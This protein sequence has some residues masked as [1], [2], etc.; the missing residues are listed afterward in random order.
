LPLDHDILGHGVYTPREAARLIG[1]TPQHVFRWTRGSGPTNPL[2]NA[3]YQFIEDS[4]E[5][6]F[7]DLIE[8]RVVAAMRRQGI[9]L[10]SIR[11]AIDFAQNALGVDRPL[12]SRD[13]KTDGSE[14]LM[15]AVEDDGEFVSLSKKAPGQKVFKKIIE[16][17]LN[18]LEYE[19]DLVARWRPRGFESI[20]LDPARSFG[21][22]LL[23]EFGVSTAVVYREFQQFDDAKYLS[24]IYEIPLQVV[25]I[26]IKYEQH[27]DK[28]LKGLDGQGSVRS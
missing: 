13:F 5:I 19:N 14:I 11:Y 20:V 22:P 23:D 2:W 8:V 16:Q 26:A 6:S 1:E 24:R 17:S 12:S 3:H 21:D 15:D 10:Q 27:L 25:R 18:D 4:T 28:K 9:S 7:L